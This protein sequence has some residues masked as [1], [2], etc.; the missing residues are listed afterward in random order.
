MPSGESGRTAL[1]PSSTPAVFIA[2][3]APVREPIHDNGVGRGLRPSLGIEVPEALLAT[4]DEVI[5]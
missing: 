1:F 3:Q 5:V 4:A 2:H